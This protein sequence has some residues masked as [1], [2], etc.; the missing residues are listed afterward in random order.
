[1]TVMDEKGFLW[2]VG[3]EE[4]EGG[5]GLGAVNDVWKSEISFSSTPTTGRTGSLTAICPGIKFPTC[6]SGLSC[7]PTVA[8][9]TS[10]GAAT[11]PL[12]KTCDLPADP[13]STTALAGW[14]IAL[15]V[16]IVVAVVA[17][18]GYFA[19][20]RFFKNA[21]SSYM[22]Q[23]GLLGSAQLIPGQDD[24]SSTTGKF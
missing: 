9:F 16:I 8:T 4:W 6:T 12:L 20:T 24:S 14:L 2:T 19:Y 5:T 3:G 21:A 23:D 22:R 10:N 1:M 7:W 17:I 15:I 11:C 18:G 13:S